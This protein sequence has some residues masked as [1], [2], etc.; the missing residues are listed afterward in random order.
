MKMNCKRRLHELAPRCHELP[1]Q[2]LF[3]NEF[4]KGGMNC[5][6]S[7][8]IVVRNILNYFYHNGAIEDCENSLSRIATKIHG[9]ANS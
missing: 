3:L 5:N 4:I 1:P 8:C 6:F 7:S 9:A 2:H